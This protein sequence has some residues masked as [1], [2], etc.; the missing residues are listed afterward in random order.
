MIDVEANKPQLTS[1]IGDQIM[2]KPRSQKTVVGHLTVAAMTVA[3]LIGA[4]GSASAM[5]GHININNG[6]SFAFAGKQTNRMMFRD[7]HSDKAISPVRLNGNYELAAGRRYTPKPKLQPIVDPLRD[8]DGDDSER[9]FWKPKWRGYRMDAR[10]H[11][12]AG[13]DHPFVAHEFCNER[14]Y[15]K[16]SYRVA[17]AWRTIGRGDRTIFTNVPQS[18]TAF[19]YIQCSR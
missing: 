8:D 9:R 6:A 2:S 17:T 16:A 15:R 4:S 11:R 18:N 13:F 10:M 12:D 7:R 14:G 1:F 19:K 3:T 5:V